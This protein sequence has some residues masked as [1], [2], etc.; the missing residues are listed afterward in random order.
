MIF[1]LLGNKCIKK[2]NIRTGTILW[3]LEPL[4]WGS[5]PLVWRS[6]VN[7][8]NN[9]VSEV[10]NV[11]FMAAEPSHP[12]T[13][14]P[15]TKRFSV[16]CDWF[17]SW[18]MSSVTFLL[19]LL[20]C[21]LRNLIIVQICPKLKA[22]TTQNSLRKRKCTMYTS[23]RC[24]MYTSVQCTVYKV[25]YLEIL[26]NICTGDPVIVVYGFIN[27]FFINSCWHYFHIYTHGIGFNIE[28][29]TWI[30]NYLLRTLNIN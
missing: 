22:K 30:F 3:G 13:E 17:S 12:H 15:R 4:V 20:T 10:R 11:G 25:N 8:G 2:E 21:T 27:C 19:N 9:G 7:F 16:L 5:E 24:T 26:I 28:L 29:G 14:H 18:F 6:E 1:C 23:V